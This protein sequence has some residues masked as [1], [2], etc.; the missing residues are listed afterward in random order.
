MPSTRLALTLGS[1]ALILVLVLSYLSLAFRTTAAP[2]ASTA[3]PCPPS[4]PDLNITRGHGPGADAPLAPSPLP[5]AHHASDGPLII[6][7]LLSLGRSA[8]W[9][10]IANVTLDA[11]DTFEP[12]G[13]VVLHPDRLFLSSGE[14]TSPAAR[15]PDG[16][17]SPGSG[18]AH[19]LVFDLP[20]GALLADA[21]L[22]LA[23]STEYHNG[24][25]DYDGAHIYAVLSERRPDSS[26][27]LHAFDPRTLDARPVLHHPADHLGAV[28]VNPLRRVV[29]ALNWGSR[30]AATFSLP[31]GRRSCASQPPLSVAT[32]P[33]H[34]VDYQD[35]KFLG[36]HDGRDVAL[37]SGVTSLPAGDPWRRYD[38]GGIALVDVATMQPI[39]EMPITLRSDR[40]AR[41]TQNPFDVA[42]HDGRLRF[43]WIPDQHQS[44]LYIYDVQP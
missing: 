42:L 12:E 34:F 22:N 17:R 8:T 2:A 21:S 23:S 13:L 11:P 39:F 29:T 38:L 36:P 6:D 18:F 26:A 10:S 32:N 5:P 15:R 40:G 25:I 4:P 16:T 20:S 7:A 27:T 44:T 43:F 30:R 3:T 37:C 1:C 35:C 41:M 19:L 31:P 9:T 28:I 33:S 14:Y 24:G